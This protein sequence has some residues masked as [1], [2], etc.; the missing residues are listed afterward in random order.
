MFNQ[1]AP[2]PTPRFEVRGRVYALLHG[3]YHH[4]VIVEVGVS[5]SDPE[6][7]LYYVHFTDH[8][9]RMDCWLPEKDIKELHGSQASLL[10]AVSRGGHAASALGI[11][12]RRRGQTESV[13][14]PLSAHAEA[15]PGTPV[16]SP[17]TAGSPV[18]SGP[19]PAQQVPSKGGGGGGGHHKAYAT[20]ARK[21]SAFFSRT[22]NIHA[23]CMGPHRV[24]TW[25]FSPYHL[26]RPLVQQRLQYAAT[27]GEEE[28]GGGAPS[29]FAVVYPGFVSASSSSSPRRPSPHGGGPGGSLLP[30]ISPSFTLHI[31]PYCV[32]PFLDHEAVVRHLQLDCLRHPPGNEIYRDPVRQLIVMELDGKVEPTFCEHLALLSKLFL[33]HKA[34]DNDMSPFLF[35]VLCAVQPQGLAVLGYFSKEKVNPDQYNLSCILVLPQ[36]QS[37]GVGRFL[38]SMSYEISRREGKVGTPEKPLSDLGEK[39]YL[40]YWSDAILTAISR[41]MDEGHRLSVDYLVQATCISQE[42]VYRTLRHLDLLPAASSS[43]DGTAGSKVGRRLSSISPAMLEKSFTARMK[44]EKEVKNFVF[45]SHLLQWAPSMYETK[46]GVEEPLAKTEYVVVEAQVQQ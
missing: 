43:S 32:H 46:S 36:F 40:N 33:E 17:S 3:R 41:A 10:K 14:S 23:I 28:R 24:G 45:Y 44:K 34:L 1:F 19:P 35:Y 22:R 5:A 31:C 4:A 29:G 2:L 9:S 16:S 27:E 7:F 30:I 11:S 8:D 21:D 13:A 12:T 39:L 20:Q 26:A 37:R 6:T 42:D 38:I 18:V 15:D 25:Y